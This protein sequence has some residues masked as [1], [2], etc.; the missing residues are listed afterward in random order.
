[1][2]PQ[3]RSHPV[4]NM[5]EMTFVS[6]PGPLLHIKDF[7]RPHL[8]TFLERSLQEMAFPMGQVLTKGMDSFHFLIERSPWKI[9]Y[10]HLVD[11]HFI[12]EIAAQV[13]ERMPF[14]YPDHIDDLLTNPVVELDICRVV[15]PLLTQDQ[16]PKPLYRL[17][18]LFGSNFPIISFTNSTKPWFGAADPNH[19]FIVPGDTQINLD[20]SRNSVDCVILSVYATCGSS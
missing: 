11:G 1:M 6:D 5:D 15:N 4:F 2:S 16:H 13:N 18:H 8:Y 9:Y 20:A 14:P 17:V 19:V 3:V 10:D 12:R 7:I